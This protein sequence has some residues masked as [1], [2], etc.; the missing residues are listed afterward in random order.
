MRLRKMI[1][2]TVIQSLKSAHRC[3]RCRRLIKRGEGA[4]RWD[5]AD[6]KMYA[7]LNLDCK[8]KKNPISL[9]E[10]F[11]GVSPSR[12]TKVFYQEPPD[13]L[14]QIGD[15]VRLDYRPRQPSKRSNTEF[16]HRSGDTGQNVLKTNLILATDKSGK[17]LYLVKKNKNSRYPRFTERGIIG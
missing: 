1:N 5:Y 12:R 13:E 17:N 6:K 2:P 14:L 4:K 16:Y 9:Y 8:I 10:Q 7:H 15:L 3:Y 11:H